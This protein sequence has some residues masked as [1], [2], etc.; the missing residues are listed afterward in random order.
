MLIDNR[1]RYAAKHNIIGDSDQ[2]TGVGV[3]GSSKEG[4][5][6]QKVVQIKSNEIV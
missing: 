2:E 6:G 5:I 1:A 3:V 4:S